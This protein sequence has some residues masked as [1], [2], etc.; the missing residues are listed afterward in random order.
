[1]IGVVTWKPSDKIW[2]SYDQVNDVRFASYFKDEPIL[3]AA[4]R[5]SRLIQKY[6]GDAYTKTNE[7]VANAKVF[8]TGEMYLIRAEARAETGAFTGAASAESDIN[9]LRTARITGYT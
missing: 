4:G 7:N 3:T 9:D 6:A 8:R 1:V 5:S 2:N